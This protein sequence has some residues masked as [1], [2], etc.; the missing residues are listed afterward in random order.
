MAFHFKAVLS[1]RLRCLVATALVLLVVLLSS[2][3]GS[4]PA[5]QQQRD[6]FQ[7]RDTLEKRKGPH[8]RLE[9]SAST[10]NALLNERI[11]QAVEKELSMPSLGQLKKYTDRYTLKL[12]RVSL[13]FDKHEGAS[14]S[15]NVGLVRGSSAILDFHMRAVAP[16]EFDETKRRVRLSVRADMFENVE[17]RP[18]KGA[19]DR[20][21][22]HLSA[23]LPRA[24]RVLIPK[25]E[26]SKVARQVIRTLSAE[27]YQ[28]LRSNVLKSVGEI[29]SLTFTLPDVPIDAIGIV[30]QG[31]V[32]AVEIRTSLNA[33][34]LPPLTSKEPSDTQLRLSMSMDTLTELGNW[35]MESGKLPN[36]YDHKGRPKEDGTFTAG[37]S[38]QGQ[39]RPLKVSLW[40]RA[41]E[42][43]LSCMYV[44][45]GADPRLEFK[46]KTLSVGFRDGKLEEIIGPPLISEAVDV[47]G[48]SDRAFAFSK[49]IATRQELVVG[50]RNMTV[51]V[52]SVRIEASV[53]TFDLDIK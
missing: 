33:H 8:L 26:I 49:R 16:L 11:D 45:A 32:L 47:L 44:R 22:S 4:C 25:R 17:V 30:T 28:Q 39:Q 51:G 24:A 10:I 1:K 50:N 21:A 53:L 29:A 15:V 35:A 43:P 18:S 42:N 31:E 52:E 7:Q 14:I 3:C 34:G 5:V 36:R 13:L 40:S 48:I 20:L 2:G 46:G 23:L 9:V 37:L 6:A 41:S 27:L 19:T 12:R 38:W